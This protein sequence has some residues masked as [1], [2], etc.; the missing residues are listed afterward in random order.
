MFSICTVAQDYVQLQ[1]FKQIVYT[2]TRSLTLKR[3][4]V[5]VEDA[6]TATEIQSVHIRGLE[7]FVSLFVRLAFEYYMY[8]STKIQKTVRDLALS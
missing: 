2:K 1:H 6:I 5:F 4:R 7:Q 3:P 8:K